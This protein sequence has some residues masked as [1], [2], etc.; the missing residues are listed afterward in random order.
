M[1]DLRRS[2]LPRRPLLWKL[3]LRLPLLHRHVWMQRLLLLTLREQKLLLMPQK[4]PLLL[5]QLLNWLK[6]LLQLQLLLVQMV[7]LL[8]KKQL[9]KLSSMLY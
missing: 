7:E 3:Q 6:K 9:R 1:L 8:V 2:V 4:T 5:E